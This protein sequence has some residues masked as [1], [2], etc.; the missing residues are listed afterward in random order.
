MKRQ[1]TEAELDTYWGP[2]AEEEALLTWR[3]AYGRFGFLV[4]LKFFQYEGRF[5]EARRDIPSEVM[6]Y[7]SSRLGVPLQHIR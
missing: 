4:L 1:W 3:T 2:T 5:P 7:L 6:R